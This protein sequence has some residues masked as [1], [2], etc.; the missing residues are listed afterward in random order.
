MSF[1]IFT[2][3]RDDLAFLIMKNESTGEY[4]EIIPDL[5]ATVHTLHLVSG[6]TV[7]SILFS[8]SH[9]EIGT[10]P[11]FRGRIL[12]PFN[13]AIPHGE[14]TFN[15]TRHNLDLNAPNENLTMHGYVYDK[16]FRNICQE[17]TRDSCSVSLQYTLTSDQMRGY[18]FNL[19]LTVTYILKNQEFNVRFEIINPGTEAA[20]LSFGWHP[21][22][23]F[24]GSIEGAILKMDSSHYLETDS[25]H[26]PTGRLLECN[27]SP[28]DFSKGVD[29]TSLVID[30][31]VTAPS[32]GTV[33]LSKDDRTI[34][35]LQD[36]NFFKYVQ[37]F[38]PNDG[39]SIA[40]EPVSAGANCFNRPELGL[41]TLEP[42]ERIDTFAS[43]RVD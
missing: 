39:T 31:A 1:T 13:D 40:L 27:D 34:T 17:C 26:I 14:Y 11:L 25:L 41:I 42:D 16:Q 8:D 3:R 28:F 43:V 32:D 33:Y 12:F 37:I 6:D 21:Y 23:T 19:T 35:L 4:A 9:D 24:D 10:N 36:T 18:P 5:G 20:P 30:N 29:I 7:R 15:N 22:F 2:E 38:S